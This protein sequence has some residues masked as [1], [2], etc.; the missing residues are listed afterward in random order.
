MNFKIKAKEENNAMKKSV[1][2]CMNVRPFLQ[3]AQICI[4]SLLKFAQTP[5]SL[6]IKQVFEAPF[7][8][9]YLPYQLN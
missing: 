3:L 9:F 6:Q 5:V 2:M 4:Y 8:P 7:S 1:K